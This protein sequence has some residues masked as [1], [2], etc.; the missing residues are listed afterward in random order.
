MN[1][2]FIE[3]YVLLQLGVTAY[4][5]GTPRLENETTVVIKIDRN[6]FVPSFTVTSLSD[7]R[8]EETAIGTSLVQVAAEDDDQIVS[9]L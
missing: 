7:R 5:N 8:S 6:S 3:Y 1:K 9:P 2:N 4:D